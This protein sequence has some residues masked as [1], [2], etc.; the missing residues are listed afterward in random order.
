MQVDVFWL[1]DRECHAFC[2]IVVIFATEPQ[3]VWRRFITDDHAMRIDHLVAHHEVGQLGAELAGLE[4]GAT[5]FDGPTML[6][7]LFECAPVT[8]DHRV[9]FT[10][11]HTFPVIVRS[12]DTFKRHV[13]HCYETVAP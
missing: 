5:T 8:G 11:R 1:D 9:T 2:G 6:R 4:E 10:G 7:Q 13:D 12:E 3:D